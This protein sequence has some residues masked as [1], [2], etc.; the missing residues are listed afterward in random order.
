MGEKETYEVVS[1]LT[2]VVVAMVYLVLVRVGVGAVIVTTD[3]VVIPLYA[4]TGGGVTVC[5]RIVSAGREVSKLLKDLRFQAKGALTDDSY[6]GCWRIAGR[7]RGAPERSVLLHGRDGAGVG[8]AFV[9]CACLCKMSP[10]LL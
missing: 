3:A 7:C 4:V 2:T 8:R 10:P 5:V 9:E 1:V 6:C